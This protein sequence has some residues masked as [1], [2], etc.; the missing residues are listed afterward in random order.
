MMMVEIKRYEANFFSG[1]VEERED[2]D[3]VRYEDSL[4]LKSA[5]QEAW[6][7][8]IAKLES[9]REIVKLA[10]AAGSVPALVCA[11][12]SDAL[13]PQTDALDR[14]RQ[15][16]K[17]KI[18]ELQAKLDTANARNAQLLHDYQKR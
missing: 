4:E 17:T 14:L 3:L 16:Y 8:A 2:G 6:L 15:P 12:L 10:R 13:D 11:Q 7:A 1:E 18:S 9:V 5:V